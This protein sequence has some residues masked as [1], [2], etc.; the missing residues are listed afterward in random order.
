MFWGIGFRV[1]SFEGLG[2]RDY[3]YIYI[4][5]HIHFLLRISTDCVESGISLDSMFESS[6]VDGLGYCCLRGSGSLLCSPLDLE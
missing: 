5:T 2:F 6:Q 1:L 4:Y 3:I